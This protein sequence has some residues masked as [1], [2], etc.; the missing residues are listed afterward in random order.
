M[1]KKPMPTPTAW[2][3]AALF[4]KAQR[5]SE[6]MLKFEHADW[7]A[8]FWSSLALELLARSALAKVSPILLADS[9]SW[10]NLYHAL[11]HEPTVPKFVPKS[12]SVT[13]VLVR[14]RDILPEFNTELERF[15]IAHIGNRN[16]ELHS[17]DVPFEG[18]KS[19][20]WRPSFY[21]AAAVLVQSLDRELAEL[22]GEEEADVAQ[23]LMTAAVDAAAKAVQG[24]ISAYKKVWE[25][26]TDA[27]R[28]AAALQATSWAAK[29]VG[30]RVQCPA[31]SSSA[32]LF[33]EAIG[34]PKKSIDDDDITEVQQ[35]LP[36]KFECVACGLKIAGLSQLSACGLGDAYKKT[37]TYDAASYYTPEDQYPDYEE[38]NNEP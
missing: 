36:S 11:G 30:H 3:S 34:A 16:A 12:I 9:A 23:K 8:A 6:E 25:G 26:K 37:T 10:H 17:G 29:H 33:G 22:V 7:R 31:C 27:D 20:S 21:R 38:D 24:D 5:Y 4:A 18:V 2:D 35:Y 19:S 13:D 15:C 28:S 14:L 1:T 32:L